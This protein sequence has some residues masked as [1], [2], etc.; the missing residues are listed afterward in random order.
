MAVSTDF[1]LSLNYSTLCSEYRLSN[2]QAKRQTERLRGRQRRG[3]A[4]CG[5]PTSQ[6]IRGGMA[7]HRPDRPPG[8]RG[9]G[10][11][12]PLPELTLDLQPEAAV[13]PPAPT[14]SSALRPQHRP[15]HL[16]QHRPQHTSPNTAPSTIR[17]RLRESCQRHT[18]PDGG[19]SVDCIPAVVTQAGSHC[20]ALHPLAG[21]HHLALLCASVSY[22]FDALSRHRLIFTRREASQGDVIQFRPGEQV[23]RALPRCAAPCRAEPPGI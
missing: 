9:A 5:L 21:P 19:Q 20:A 3:T 11:C 22:R 2:V 15:Q 6:C 1:F 16:P 10:R 12:L 14:R 4:V 23:T 13:V 7:P 18:T 17:E 8:A